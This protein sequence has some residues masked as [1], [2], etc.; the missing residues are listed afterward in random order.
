MAA[1][2][3]RFSLDAQ[4]LETA[5]AH[6]RDRRPEQASS[7]FLQV[8]GHA[9]RDVRTMYGLAQA[10]LAMGQHDEGIRVAR[11]ALKLSPDSAALHATLGLLLA[12]SG[13]VGRARDAFRTAERL[14]PG[15]LAHPLNLAAALHRLGEFGAAVETYQ[16]VAEKDPGTVAAWLGLG[17]ALLDDEQPLAALAALERARALASTDPAVWMALGTA[18]RRLD[19]TDDAI[20]ALE[21]AATHSA[22]PVPAI[23]AIAATQRSVGRVRDA[24]DTLRRGLERFPDAANLRVSL[25]YT[26]RASSHDAELDALEGLAAR[27]DAASSPSHD[28]WFAV[29]KVRRDLGELE[30]A[31]DAT[32]HAN[33]ARRGQIEFEVGPHAAHFADVRRTLTQAPT[34]PAAEG[35]G[36]VPV[37]VLGMPRSGTSLLEQILASHPDVYGGGELTPLVRV[38]ERGPLP[39]T[40]PQGI[41]RARAEHLAAAGNAYLD[42]VRARAGGKPF[43]TDKCLTNF[44]Y[45]GGIRAAIP[46]ARFVHCVRDP[47]DTCLSIYEQ[48]FDS[49]IPYAFDQREVAHV[50]RLYQE[51]MEHW[52]NVLG[53]GVILDVRYEDLVADVEQETRRLLD[54][55]G[56]DWHQD[57]LGFHRNPRPVQTASVLQVREPAYTSSIGRWRAVAHR[58]GPMLEVLGIEDAPEPAP[59]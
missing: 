11:R 42:A 56:L 25:A 35:T 45:V 39:S 38:L 51:M 59:A 24:V 20:Q 41:A 44:L 36:P 23:H 33:A 9:P 52:H 46:G 18:L 5:W 6:L 16:R 7:L 2:D 53:P 3:I 21:N 15:S 50:H 17:R 12:S 8:L 1:K 10:H 54:H 28:L 37:F 58:I 32:E 55:V 14:E 27:A 13:Q 30:S 22:D 29:A 49:G 4:V 34:A 26:V 48:N 57:C 43:A 31:F 19:R 47:R 40:Y